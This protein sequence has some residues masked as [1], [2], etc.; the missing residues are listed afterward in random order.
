MVELRAVVTGYGPLGGA[1]RSWAELVPLASLRPRALEDLGEP[2]VAD[3]VVER[4]DELVRT[5]FVELPH[6]LRALL[7]QIR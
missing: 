7:S 6:Q 4:G 2:C 3:P 1:D 5:E